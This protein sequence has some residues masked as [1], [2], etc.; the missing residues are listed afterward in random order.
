[1]S[2]RRGAQLAGGRS[3]LSAAEGGTISGG[4]R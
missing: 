2:G 3:G 1:M 4:S